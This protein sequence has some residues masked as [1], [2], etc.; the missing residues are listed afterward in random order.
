M[1]ETRLINDPER[2]ELS[3]QH[4]VEQAIKDY[5]LRVVC[6]AC[7]RRVPTR[8]QDLPPK[9]RGRLIYDLRFTCMP[10]LANRRKPW[11]GPAGKH[12]AD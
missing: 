6:L 11:I 7:N 9:Y 1:A 10:C 3:K 4:T 12:S 5:S 2:L 8:L